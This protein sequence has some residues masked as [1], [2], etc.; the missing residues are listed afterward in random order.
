MSRGSV[1]AVPDLHACE[2]GAQAYF[3]NAKVV[4]VPLHSGFDRFPERFR[5]AGLTTLHSVW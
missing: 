5:L 4:L 3:L 1:K 2:I